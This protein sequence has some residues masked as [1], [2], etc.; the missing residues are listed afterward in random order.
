MLGNYKM[1]QLSYR[2]L[3]CELCDI[4]ND[5]RQGLGK[6]AELVPS[7]THVEIELNFQ[8]WLGY[9]HSNS[10]FFNFF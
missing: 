3:S 9:R 4:K 7:R 1:Q 5:Q 6:G 10:F 2:N 8:E